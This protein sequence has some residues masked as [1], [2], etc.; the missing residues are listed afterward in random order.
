MFVVVVVVVVV[1]VTV[2]LF[3]GG[4]GMEHASNTRWTAIPFRGEGVN[5]R[6]LMVASCF[7][8]WD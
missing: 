4:G 8:Y 7:W 6:I 3:F 1:V 5:N 2:A